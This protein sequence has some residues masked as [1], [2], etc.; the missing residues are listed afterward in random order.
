MKSL[1]DLKLRK[2]VNSTID[3]KNLSKIKGGNESDIMPLDGCYSG[4]CSKQ[5]NTSYCDGG[6]VCT[7]GIAG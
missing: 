2:L 1:D 5:I 6:A 4:I 7:C 3:L